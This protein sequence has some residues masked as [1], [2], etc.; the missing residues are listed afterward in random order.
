VKI[1]KEGKIELPELREFRGRRAEIVILPPEE[2]GIFEP[3][4]RSEEVRQD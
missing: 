3:V 4:N 1:G 2:E